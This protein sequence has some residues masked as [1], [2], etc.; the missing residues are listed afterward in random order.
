MVLKA[1]LQWRIKPGERGITVIDVPFVIQFCAFILEAVMAQLPQVTGKEMHD[2]V[3]RFLIRANSRRGG[4][5]RE[6][7]VGR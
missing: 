1:I 7:A 6:P 2:A 5:G 4:F 3:C